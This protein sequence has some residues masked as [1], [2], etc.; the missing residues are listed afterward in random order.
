MGKVLSN[1]VKSVLKYTL[2]KLSLLIVNLLKLKKEISKK[3]NTS[4]KVK[5]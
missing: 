5:S 3:H 2:V 1:G 4:V